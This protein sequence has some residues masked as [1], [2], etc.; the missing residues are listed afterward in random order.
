MKIHDDLYSIVIDIWV[1]QIRSGSL[2]SQSSNMTK[3]QATDEAGPSTKRRMTISFLV[4][5]VEEESSFSHTAV[6]S[7]D[8]TI[9][10]ESGTTRQTQSN[11]IPSFWD[12][13]DLLLRAAA[14]LSPEPEPAANAAT[15]THTGAIR[16]S[17]LQPVVAASSSIGERSLNI[18]DVPAS[19]PD[20]SKARKR[21]SQASSSKPKRAKKEKTQADVDGTEEVKAEIPP[22]PKV[23]WSKEQLQYLRELDGQAVDWSE[24]TVLFAARFPNQLRSKHALQVRL[25]RLY[26]L[27]GRIPRWK[28][29]R[30]KK[31]F[32][33]MK[34][35]ATEQPESV[36]AGNSGEA[37]STAAH[38]SV[39]ET[40]V[41]ENAAAAD[42][43][44]GP[45][46]AINH[47]H[48]QHQS[49]QYETALEGR[50]EP[51]SEQPE[52]KDNEPKY[53]GK[54]KGRA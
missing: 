5:T 29:Y 21:T 44:A 22:K 38:R 15:T 17:P 18:S 37:S 41:V 19:S 40:G 35:E 14:S 3:R 26:Q 42:Y 7:A 51:R 30:T 36:A 23:R 32:Q 28:G 10:T 2:N 34:L 4:E 6:E 50:K 9:P 46:V 1:F 47:G 12:K 49:E 48:Q 33:K 54:G 31:N 8:T 53:E 20:D 52:S 39:A 25:G 43:A 24:I 45:W 16:Q 11:Y 13:V 27:E